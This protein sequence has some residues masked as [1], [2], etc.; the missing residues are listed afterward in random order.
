MSIISVV[1]NKNIKTI[2]LCHQNVLFWW[3]LHIS[4]LSWE[5]KKTIKIYLHKLMCIELTGTNKGIYLSEP[6]P[7]REGYVRIFSDYI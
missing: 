5:L 6:D 1:T 4:L 7:I 3:Y 2:L